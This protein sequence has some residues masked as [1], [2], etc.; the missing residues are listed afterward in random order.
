MPPKYPTASEIKLYALTDFTGG[1]NYR[2]DPFQLHENESPDMLNVD[3]DPR[4]GISMRD[5][6]SFFADTTL[7]PKN[8]WPFAT[9]AARSR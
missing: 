7:T 4:G 1:L 2:A 9:A 3:L 8:L 5:G 6:I